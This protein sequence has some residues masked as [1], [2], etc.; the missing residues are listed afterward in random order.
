MRIIESCS[1]LYKRSNTT[2]RAL[3]TACPDSKSHTS[4]PCNPRAI[5]HV[6]SASGCQS[7]QTYWIKISYCIKISYGIYRLAHN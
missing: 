1:E 7:T 6:V 3:V 5:L 2:G 4:M